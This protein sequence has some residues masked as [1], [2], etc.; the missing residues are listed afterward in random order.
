MLAAHA[1]RTLFNP[2]LQRKIK[3]EHRTPCSMAHYL[4]K[5][6]AGAVTA[7]KL[8]DDVMLKGFVHG[9]GIETDNGAIILSA[10]VSTAKKG[11]SETLPVLRLRFT[12]A[13][14]RQFVYACWQ[15]FLSENARRKMWTVGNQ[16]EEIYRRVVNETEPLVFFHADAADNLRAIAALLEAVA[17]EA[18]VS[19]LAA[20]EAEIRQTDD[21]ID[22]MV[23]ELYELTPDEIA[24][25]K[26][27]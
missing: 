9:I 8:I 23:Y 11:E 24:L 10:R 22:R 26:A 7:E 6:Y 14:L 3:H 15:Q 20:L 27:G 12:H 2:L 5:D 21:E 18:G 25:V 1:K 16:P 19:D 13:A 4:Q 17:A